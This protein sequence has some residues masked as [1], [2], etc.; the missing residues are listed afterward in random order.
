MAFKDIYSV[1]QKADA[2]EFIYCLI[3]KLKFIYTAQ[4]LVPLGIENNSSG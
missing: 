1:S 3:K 2:I 4:E